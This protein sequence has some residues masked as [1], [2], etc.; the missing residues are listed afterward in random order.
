MAWIWLRVASGSARESDRITFADEVR[1]QKIIVPQ[2]DIYR[3]NPC[4]EES[5]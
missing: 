2:L 3:E 5:S 1:W 4:F